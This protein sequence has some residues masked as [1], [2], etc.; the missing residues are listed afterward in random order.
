MACRLFRITPSLKLGA[1]AATTAEQKPAR[2]ADEYQK[3]LGGGSR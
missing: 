2:L 1:L 3:L